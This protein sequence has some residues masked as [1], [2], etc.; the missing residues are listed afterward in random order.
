VSH[1]VHVVVGAPIEVTQKAKPTE[2]EVAQL[3][4]RYE[5][6]LIALYNAHKPARDPPLRIY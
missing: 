5:S 2:E 3:H 4:A 1:P 6:Q